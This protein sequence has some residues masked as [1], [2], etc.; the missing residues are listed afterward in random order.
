MKSRNAKY[1]CSSTALFTNL[2]VMYIHTIMSLFPPLHTR[3]RF[4]HEAATISYSRWATHLV[5]HCLH[6]GPPYVWLTV[7]LHH[8]SSVQREGEEA[9]PPLGRVPSDREEVE[10]LLS[11]GGKSQR[12]CPYYRGVLIIT[13][14]TLRAV[15]SL[16]CY[17]T[18]TV[19]IEQRHIKHTMRDLI[20]PCN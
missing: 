5:H 1:Q 8:S 14:P 13:A 18:H 15:T 3:G 7:S 20:C 9:A 12:T 16:R 10:E 17:W 11:G 6:P 4:L 19:H 2:K